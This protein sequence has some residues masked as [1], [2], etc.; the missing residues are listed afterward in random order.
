[1]L[2]VVVV[3]P[4]HEGPC[5]LL[6]RSGSASHVA[7]GGRGDR[8]GG[9]QRPDGTRSTAAADRRKSLETRVQTPVARDPLQAVPR[10]CLCPGWGD[11]LI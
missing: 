7:L 1:M 2:G 5:L 3:R 8:A 11:G 6:V 9:C 4:S 10:V